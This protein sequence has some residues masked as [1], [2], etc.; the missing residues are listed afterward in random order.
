MTDQIKTKMGSRRAKP[1]MA[2][3]LRLIRPSRLAVLL[4]CEPPQPRQGQLRQQQGLNSLTVKLRLM[5]RAL[6]AQRELIRKIRKATQS[7][8]RARIPLPNAQQ[9]CNLVRLRQ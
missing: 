5:L 4:D 9:T 8:S 3:T 6:R 7:V 2:S 1:E